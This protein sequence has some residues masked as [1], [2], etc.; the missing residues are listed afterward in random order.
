MKIEKFKYVSDLK[1]MRFSQRPCSGDKFFGPLFF[2]EAPYEFAYDRDG[3]R[4]EWRIP[5]FDATVDPNDACRNAKLN[6]FTDFASVP[7]IFRALVSRT[8]S[9]TE[10]A[11]VHDF[12]YLLRHDFV[13]DRVEEATGRPPG[14]TS[15][16]EADL[17]MLRALEE[18]KV[19]RCKRHVIFLAVHLAGW[20]VY[21]DLAE[22]PIG[23]AII[24]L[25]RAAGL[26][27]L[28]WI[29]YAVFW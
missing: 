7:P 1:V 25:A 12:L 17:V 5:K 6:V 14:D 4:R 19:G 29:I 13:K 8:G 24:W 28:A 22:K 21:D 15:R 10:A 18:A 27:L 20:W 23:K 3:A 9:H 11:V 2:F 26:A 16:K